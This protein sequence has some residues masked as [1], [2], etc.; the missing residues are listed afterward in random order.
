M[1]VSK[2][3]GLQV[4][5]ALAALSVA[6]FHSYV[7]VRGFPE[8]AASPIYALSQWGYL[9]VDLFFAVSGYV[10]CLVASKPNFSRSSFFI[11]RAFRLYPMYLAVMCLVALLAASG[12]YHI[13]S[14]SHFLYSLTLLPQQGAPAY[15]LS[16]TLEREIVFYMLAMII[17]PVGGIRG[18]AV[19]LAV[20]SLGGWYF[21]EPWTFHLVSIRQAS[22]LAGVLV[23]LT[24]PGINRLGFIVPI[25]IGLA[26][27]ALF[28]SL[29][30]DPLRPIAMMF[31]LAAMVNL[32]LP[33]TRWPI[34]WFVAAGDASYS[35]YLLHYI[36]FYLTT[37]VAK[38]LFS[39][40]PALE[41]NWLCEPWRWGAIAVACTVSQLTWKL[42]ESPMIALGNAISAK[43][44]AKPVPIPLPG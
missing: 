23:F 28:L 37:V 27:L 29:N 15:D 33:W 12:H 6:Y 22:F 2:N 39:R 40:F 42:I 32:R 19:V 18:L 4:A 31:I 1:D 13:N 16:W 21:G 34:R 30:S 38:L 10:I 5:R 24:L 9:G 14:I 8:A 36:V 17:V 44:A 26:V 3:E 35:I 41:Q 25:G 43:F 11:K 20:L 7:A